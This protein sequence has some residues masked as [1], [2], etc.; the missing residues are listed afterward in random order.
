MIQVCKNEKTTLGM[1]SVGHLLPR[2]VLLRPT[3]LGLIMRRNI[4][5]NTDS[6]LQP[7]YLDHSFVYIPCRL[8]IHFISNSKHVFVG[9]RFRFIFVYDHRFEL[10]DLVSVV[11]FDFRN[12][13][14]R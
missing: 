12:V 14:H 1:I 8:E 4:F 13:T 11:R 7:I 2:A 6:L 3:T 5:L 9:I 10:S